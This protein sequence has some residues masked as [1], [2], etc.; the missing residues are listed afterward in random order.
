MHTRGKPL[1]HTLVPLEN[2]ENGLFFQRSKKVTDQSANRNGA[3]HQMPSLNVPT[4]QTT[5]YIINTEL[6]YKC[7]DYY[8]QFL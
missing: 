7:V 3:H 5:I 6:D 2:G 1:M 4:I 8:D